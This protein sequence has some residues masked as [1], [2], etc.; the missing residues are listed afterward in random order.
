MIENK[1]NSEAIAKREPAAVEYVPYG[2][3]DKI[4]MTVAV[5]QNLVAVKTKTGK[6]CSE[7]DAIKFMA[8]CQAKRLNPFEG[9]AFLIGYDGKDG[10]V[11]SLITAHQTY[12]KRAE[13]HPEFDGMK[14]G[15]IVKDK[16]GK[17]TDLEGDF[18]S[19]GQHVVGGW[20]TVFFKNRKQ[21]MH[22]RLR[23]AR[24]N[25][26][27]GVWQDDPGGMICKC[28]D[29][30]TEVLTTRGFERF[31]VA[32][33]NILQ[34]TQC[35]LEP[36]Q[37]VPFVQ[38]YSGEM[39]E[40]PSD[41][42]N[43]CVTPNH[44]MLTTTGVIEAGRMFEQA[45]IRPK[46]LIPRKVANRNADAAISDQAI[47]LA[48]A[49]LADGADKPHCSFWIS[50]SRDRKI[51]KLESLNL[52]H[53][54]HE[55]H[56]AG[57][58]AKTEG[59][60]ITTRK[61][62][63]MF[64]FKFALIDTL[65]ERG[66]KPCMEAILSL[67]ARQARIFADTLVEFDGNI[68]KRTGVKRFG[69][70]RPEVMSAFELASVLA[71]YS[72]SNRKSRTSD[73]S[74]K[75]HAL[76]TISD[77]DAIPVRKTAARTYSSLRLIPNNGGKVWC[78]EVPSHTIVVRRHGFSMLCNNCAEADA[79][80]S[81]FPTM[82]GGLY[83]R[84]EVELLPASSKRDFTAPGKPLFG[85][86][87]EVST[88]EPEKEPPWTCSCRQK[89]SGWATKCG[90]CN[91][92]KPQPEVGHPAGDGDLGPQPASPSS[93]GFNPPT[94]PSS[95]GAP[96]H[97]YPGDFNPLKTLRDLLKTEKITEAELLDFWSAIGATDGS[98]NGLEDVL[99][100]KGEDWMK[101][102]TEAWP[103]TALAIKAAKKKGGQK[104]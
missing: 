61:N 6:T 65:V 80:R 24:F 52:H 1:T 18:Y 41:D 15:I 54:R 21:P 56:C 44:D 27:Y 42:L 9:D 26:G 89:N 31:A 72:V 84:E 48:A 38:Q 2:A 69:A 82:L 68:N 4:K 33:G 17:L 8:M 34:V 92:P 13:L 50:V 90:R 43:F 103:A 66:K 67:S 88:P 30:E 85:T 91:K 3:Q 87:L 40:Y 63:A 39:V 37:A 7:R 98:F 96:T 93:G 36:T 78:V 55:Q 25:K 83:M 57:A 64:G 32:E 79:L 71:G 16:E 51:A 11:F 104:A 73:I 81:S 22:R 5:I 62:K 45:T 53:A 46:F 102:Q 59:R 101:S 75:P 94:G 60:T 49:Y 19:E 29:E 58:V 14:S 95:P 86:T 70:S 12:L 47:T 35:G 20:A 76:V 74:K 99:L 97:P 28:F 77:R 10:P 23:V 100:G